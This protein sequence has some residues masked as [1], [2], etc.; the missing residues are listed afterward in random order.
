MNT[1]HECAA[2]RT[3]MKQVLP[4]KECF[5]Y[6]GKNKN[7]DFFQLNFSRESLTVFLFIK[8]LLVW[9]R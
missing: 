9:S 4:L 2:P 6:F 8:G 3:T 7:D 5:S 1:N